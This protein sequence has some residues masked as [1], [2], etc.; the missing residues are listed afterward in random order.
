MG[1]LLLCS[2]LNEYKLGP[3][4]KV[5]STAVQLF[6]AAAPGTAGGDGAQP[7]AGQRH[8]CRRMRYPSLPHILVVRSKDM[9]RFA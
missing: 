1:W 8:D 4:E 6:P 9:G 7:P 2:A 3:A 5:K